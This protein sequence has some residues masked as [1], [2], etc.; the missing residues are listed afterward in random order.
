MLVLLPTIASCDR[1]GDQ[2]QAFLQA[3]KYL[4]DKN[5]AGFLKASA[6]L[7]DYPLYPYLRYQWLRNHLSDTEQVVSF[8]SL[9]NNTRYAPLLKASWL[10]YLAKN[11]RWGEFFVNYEVNDK[12]TEDC[13]FY[14]AQH[15]IGK[16]IE[17][18]TEAKRLWSSGKENKGY[19][20]PL[21]S[22]LQKSSFLTPE[23]N[24]QRFEAA[25]THKNVGLAKSVSA[26]M[27]GE[28][29]S[30]AE[31][32]LTL[33]QQP[34]AIENDKFWRDKTDRTG[35]LFAHS[36]KQFLT[37]DLNKAMLIWDAR[38]AGFSIDDAIAGEVEHRFGMALLSD[39]DPKAYGH[40]AK[41]MSPDE[42]TRLAKVRAALVEQDW[43]HVA[44]AVSGLTPDEKQLPQWRYW[45][46]RALAE[47]GDAK[48]AEIL[49]QA[50]AQDR[51]FYGF[52]AAD[53]IKAPYQFSDHPVNTDGKA[54]LALSEEPDFK[55]CQ[56]FIAV[57]MEL[58][59][60]RQWQF[61][62]KNLPKEKLM[63]AAKLAQQWQW[64]QIAITT[65]VKAD[66]WDDL[67]LRFPLHYFDLVKMNADQQQL[68][69]ALI[70]GLMR[71][72]SMLDKD[73]VSSVGARGL[74]QLMPATA[75][76][77]AQSMQEKLGSVNDLYSPDVNIRYGSH[78]FK[79][80]LDQFTGHAALAG[81]A[82]N[83]GPNK[84]KKWLPMAAAIPADVWIDTIPYKETR[85]YVTSVLSYA[86][87]YQNRLKSNRFRLKDLLPDVAP[88]LNLS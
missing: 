31:T 16:Q 43:Q 15:Q 27:T 54:L 88:S 75:K 82:Y 38:K 77:V 49:L 4:N 19:C 18:L 57:N 21:F 56:E 13:R 9:Y 2:R 32:W 24:W 25:L 74:L 29:K 71:Q 72:E 55:V 45:Q 84:V 62:I 48:Q 42:D 78:Y 61:A 8:L 67:A 11:K 51:S 44:A 50:L 85:K 36:V 58:E 70:Y 1:L 69:P 46:A 47:T 17:A 76:T 3:Q 80:L 79:T 40:L 87:I 53:R 34:Q 60:H 52:L 5:E 81:A 6:D 12:S 10:D 33:H 22:E 39:K 65:L 35:R 14:W 66:Y 86:I 20:Q 23:N 30:D 68:D 37:Q 28:D 63:T 41:V 26:L 83:A 64:H 7:T 59:A 73:A